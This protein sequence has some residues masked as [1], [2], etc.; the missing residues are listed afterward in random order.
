MTET[1]KV[2]VTPVFHSP[3]NLQSQNAVGNQDSVPQICGICEVV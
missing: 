2:Y 1:V 3:Q